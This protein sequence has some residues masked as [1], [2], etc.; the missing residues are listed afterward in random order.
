MSIFVPA[1]VETF[2]PALYL[3]ERG[4]TVIGAVM[5]RDW[6]SYAALLHRKDQ[7]MQVSLFD[8]LEG[9]KAEVETLWDKNSK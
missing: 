6:N 8:T 7:P 5:S 4:G 3:Y 1:W 9:A 2:K